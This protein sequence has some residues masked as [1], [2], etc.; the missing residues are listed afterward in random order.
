MT[1]T[2]NAKALAFVPDADDTL[3]DLK[4]VQ[5]L[6]GFRSRNAVEAAI[7]AGIIPNSFKIAGSRR[8]R[9]FKVRAAI[10]ALELAANPPDALA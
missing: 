2:S 1:N 3:I 6:T 8:W 10:A 9:L 7:T 4:G 5:A